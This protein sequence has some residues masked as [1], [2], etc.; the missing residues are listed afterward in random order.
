MIYLTRQEQRIA[1]LL[2]VVLLLS[3]G[4]LLV[5]RFQPGWIMRLSIGE[6]DFDV[7]KD[8]KSPRLASD[9]PTRKEQVTQGQGQ[10]LED[11]ASKST[12]QKIQEQRTEQQPKIE[13][14]IPEVKININTASKEELETLP[15]IGP[16][17]AQNIIDHRQKHGRFTSVDELLNVK[18]IGDKTLQKIRDLVIVGK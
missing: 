11:T 6:P 10:K 16:V 13:K 14:A 3:T 17:R 18:G 7:E 1:I 8:Q 4:V 9:Y 2:G 15:G 5:K 12:S